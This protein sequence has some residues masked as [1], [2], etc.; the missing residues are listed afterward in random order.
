MNSKAQLSLYLNYLPQ[1]PN[2]IYTLNLISLSVHLF[3]N[4]T[5]QFQG[6]SS[7][8]LVTAWLQSPCP[9]NALT[10]ISLGKVHP[11][12]HIGTAIGTISTQLLISTISTTC[13]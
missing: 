7:Y 4:F 1:W 12:S 5:P 8:V 11:V 6:M 13:M 3:I 2:L 9:S 10:W